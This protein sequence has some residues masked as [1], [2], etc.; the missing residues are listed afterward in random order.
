MGNLL[1]SAVQGQAMTGL[2]AII[3]G[4]EGVGKT[5]LAC[6]APDSLLIP[7]ESGY[8]V[9]TT[10]R[11]PQMTHWLHIEQAIKEITEAAETGKLPYK[12]IVY[13]TGTALEKLL[14]GFVIEKDTNWSQGNPKGVTMESALGGYGKAYVLAGTLFDE[15][16]RK[17]DNL[18]VYYGVNIIITCHIF[19][20]RVVN[21]EVGEYDCWDLQLHAPKN[22]KTFGKRESLTQ[23]ADLIGI[24][25]GDFTI[26]KNEKGETLRMGIDKG[27][28]DDQRI[29]E[30]N[31]TPAYVAKNRFNMTGDVMIPRVGGWNYLAKAIYDASGRDFW[32]RKL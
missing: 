22:Q 28:T 26:R 15:F 10:A 31:R 16:L 30:V 12:T 32:N 27:T 3:G 14:H 25:H 23:W 6:S 8:G 7:V 1:E 2:R 18:A 13:D 5:T 24:M 29:M 11:L 9:I 17:L 21:P 19:A 4:V 20:A